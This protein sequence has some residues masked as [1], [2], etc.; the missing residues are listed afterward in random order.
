MKLANIEEALE[1]ARALDRTPLRKATHTQMAARLT[2]ERERT[3]L[4][5]AGA[6]HVARLTRAMARALTPHQIEWD[7]WST[8]VTQ[9]AT[10]ALA[11]PIWLRGVIS[12]ATTG[13]R[14]A[15]RLRVTLPFDM[16]PKTA[17]QFAAQVATL[18][19]GAD[20]ITEAGY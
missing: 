14:F 10:D 2:E 6:K 17:E 11:S 1:A 16:H 13:P 5:K 15:T 8:G 18:K 4:A 3:A 7:L 19:A 12:P 20:A 9:T